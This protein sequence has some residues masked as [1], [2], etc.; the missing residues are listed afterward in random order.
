MLLL[1]EAT[2]SVMYFYSLASSLGGMYPV[3]ALQSPGLD[4]SF[5]AI[6]D[7]KELALFHRQNLR[8]QHITGPHFLVGHSA[9][10]RV[11]YELAWL[12]EQEGEQ[13]QGLAILDT[14]APNSP[15][16]HDEM[17]F[18]NEYNWLH[19]IVY[20]F[21]TTQQTDLNVSVQDLEAF[22]NL[23][24]AYE[25]VMELFRQH[26]IFAPNT[27]LDELKAMVNVYKR[28][29][30]ADQV[31]VMP[32]NLHCPIHLFCASESTDGFGGLANREF[33]TQGWPECTTAE[34]REHWVGGNHMSMM[35]SPHVENWTAILSE[36]F[37]PDQGENNDQ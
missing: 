28:T 21:E 37:T 23:E 32:G 25:H 17:D 24:A 36:Y 31:Y 34:V 29:C 14:Y 4:G 6:Q 1:P 27:S 19:D 5:A 2:G 16:E 15:P 33:V 9:G 8:Q 7:L 35:F 10:G 12:L 20:A 13:V 3:Y 18:Y 30:Q 26:N 22:G 11:A